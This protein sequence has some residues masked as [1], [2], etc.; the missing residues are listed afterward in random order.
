M[1]LGVELELGKNPTSTIP[2]VSSRTLFTKQTD[3]QQT[4]I[5]IS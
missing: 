5:C 1:E 4:E 2:V 3:R